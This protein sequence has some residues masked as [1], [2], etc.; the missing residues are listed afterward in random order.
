MENLF[1]NGSAERRMLDNKYLR[2]LGL[3]LLLCLSLIA[4]ELA[5]GIKGH[6]VR[7]GWLLSGIPSILVITFFGKMGYLFSSFMFLVF[8]AG[9][10]SNKK[11][12]VTNRLRNIA[13]FVFALAT[14]YFY[15]RWDIT[16]IVSLSY[17]L[18]VVMFSLYLV[19]LVRS[20]F[21]AWYKSLLFSYALCLVSLSCFFPAQLSQL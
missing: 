4:V 19:V 1:R 9:S 20:E 16:G 17:L 6:E 15:I 18:S 13:I 12:I 5:I 2:K 21:K 8:F 7:S 11:A 3:V 10:I 14:L